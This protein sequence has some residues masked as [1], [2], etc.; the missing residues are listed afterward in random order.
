LQK[1]SP[2]VTPLGIVGENGDTRIFGLLPEDRRKHAW[3]VGM[4]GTGKTTALLLPMIR[5]DMARG[6]RVIVFDP[7]G[8]LA[9]DIVD[10]ASADQLRDIVRFDPDDSKHP[11]HFNPFSGIPE[12]RRDRFARGMAEV[13][14]KLLWESWESPWETVLH[15]AVRALL[16]YPDATIL[17]L[18]RMLADEAYGNAVF[19]HAEGKGFAKAHG[20][21]GL[22]PTLP[23][24]VGRLFS[25]TVWAKLSNAEHRRF[26]LGEALREGKTAI[27]DLSKGK[28]GAETSELLNGML[29]LQL[30]NL[31]LENGDMPEAESYDVWSISTNSKIRRSPPWGFSFRKGKGADSISRSRTNIL[32]RFRRQ[33]KSSFLKISVRSLRFVL[34]CSMRKHLKRLSEEPCRRRIFPG[35][36]GIDFWYGCPYMGMPKQIWFSVFYG[37][38]T[39]LPYLLRD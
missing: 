35:W 7:H 39:S 26:E 30:E 10:G 24:A 6:K 31:M 16:E 34:E 8:S 18:P 11:W 36:T 22:S 3:I 33:C 12:N 1:D 19:R 9:Q 28:I 32:P 25:D 21:S 37:Y 13:F 2:D 17:S 38:D 20:P 27:F 15:D 4:T 23:K 14:Q 29:L 5:H